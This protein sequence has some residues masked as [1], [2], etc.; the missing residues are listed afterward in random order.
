MNRSIFNGAR[1]D[2]PGFGGTSITPVLGKLRACQ[3][4]TSKSRIPAAPPFIGTPNRFPVIGKL[5]A[6]PRVVCRSRRPAFLANP[7]IASM[8]VIA[9]IP[10]QAR[11]SARDPRR[12]RAMVLL[13]Q[14]R[15]IYRL[16]ESGARRLLEAPGNDRLLEGGNAILPMPSTIGKQRSYM[17]RASRSRSPILVSA[18][19][20]A[21]TPVVPNI[22]GKLRPAPRV[23]TRSRIPT[24]S[25]FI[26]VPNRFPVL[27]K[28]RATPRIL[29]R[30]GSRGRHRRLES[31]SRAQQ[32]A[33]RGDQPIA[34]VGPGV[35]S[36]LRFTSLRRPR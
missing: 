23:T 26:G 28:L 13:T 34:R 19:V 9:P 20:V 29:P 11:R 16:L 27:G 22:L 18:P 6:S 3:R 10:R 12:F 4:V 15:G 5:R 17:V 32:W 25:P 2:G 21:G 8:P 7:P 33:S 36:S 30:A 35:H 14:A 31:R 1:F 24:A